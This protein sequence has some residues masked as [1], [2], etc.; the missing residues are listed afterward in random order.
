MPLI[1]F[2][3]NSNHQTIIKKVVEK[4]RCWLYWI[5]DQKELENKEVKIE[6]GSNNKETIT[7]FKELGCQV[8]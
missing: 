2:P 3:P 5:G 1:I 6:I 7:T 4:V 8:N